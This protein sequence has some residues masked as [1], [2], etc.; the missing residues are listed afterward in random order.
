MYS[1]FRKMSWKVT[2]LLDPSL[3]YFLFRPEFMIRARRTSLGSAR[4]LAQGTNI[5]L[6]LPGTGISMKVSKGEL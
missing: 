3:L 1:R 6:T 5:C 4:T 2:T